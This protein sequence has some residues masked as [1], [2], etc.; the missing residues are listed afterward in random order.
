MTEYKKTENDIAQKSS[1]VYY[2][3]QELE[4]LF[5]AKK[6]LLNEDLQNINNDFN[7]KYREQ[8]DNSIKD[9]RWLKEELENLIH[10]VMLLIAKKEIL[11]EI[12]SN[13]ELYFSNDILKDKNT[14][15]K[16]YKAIQER[17]D[18]FDFIEKEKQLN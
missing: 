8:L 5:T 1:I 3:S 17:I 9:D 6:I 7:N 13:A 4:D 16:I 14:A 2:D 12:I 10:E 15:V 18:I 11:E